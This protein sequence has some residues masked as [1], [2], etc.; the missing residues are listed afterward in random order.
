MASSN[1]GA[2]TAAVHIS[3]SS[4]GGPGRTTTAGPRPDAGATTAPGAVPTG[5]RI[6]AP[7]GTVACLRVPVRTASGSI[8]RQRLSIGRRMYSMRASRAGS[9]TIARPQNS[10]TIRIV[11]SSAVGPRPPEVITRSMPSAAM[12]RSWAVMSSGRSPQIE[13]CAR[14]TPSSNRR[15]ASHGPLRSCTR[16]V[17]TSVPVTTIPARTLTR[18]AGRRGWRAVRSRAGP[19]FAGGQRLGPA[20][21]ELVADDAGARRQRDPLAVVEDAHGGCIA[22]V[23]AQALAVE[24]LR[25]GRRALVDHRGAG[26]AVDAQVRGLER[27]DVEAHRGRL[28]LGRPLLLG[29]RGLV[30]LVLRLGGRGRLLAALVAAACKPE[31]G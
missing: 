2:S 5:F 18:A 30:L 28:G 6:V 11:R 12:K 9:W 14:S 25:V 22:D 29:T 17:S 20:R 16:P 26:A 31:D 10:A 13:M 24:G 23:H 7:S 8:P 27:D 1:S 3:C 21:R 19:R 4:R 15:S